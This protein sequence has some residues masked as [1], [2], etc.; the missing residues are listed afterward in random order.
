M[1]TLN[2][3]AKGGAYTLCELRRY[4]AVL[5]TLLRYTKR[6]Q[7]NRRHSCWQTS[8]PTRIDLIITDLRSAKL[9]KTKERQSQGLTMHQGFC[10]LGNIPTT[11]AL[12][13]SFQIFGRG[14]RTLFCDKVA[15]QGSSPLMRHKTKR[16]QPQW[17]T[18]FCWWSIKDS[19]LGPTGYEPVALTN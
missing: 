11:C 3:T 4:S 6:S 17:L 7:S 13:A 2:L 14:M 19:N 10:P 8:L 1:I 15:E 16:G 9:T 5:R 18:S 12:K